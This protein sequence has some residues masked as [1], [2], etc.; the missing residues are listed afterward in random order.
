MNFSRRGEELALRLRVD[1]RIHAES[2]YVV[3]LD[4]NLRQ[5]ERKS[6]NKKEGR[7]GCS[8]YIFPGVG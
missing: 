2:V 3:S 6:N 1:Q 4:G 7:A 8:L 5:T